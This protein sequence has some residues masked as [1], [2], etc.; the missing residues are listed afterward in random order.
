MKNMESGRL[1]EL[2]E[3]SA[4]INSTLDG[5]EIR[6]R[7]MEAAKRLVNAET[8]SLLLV[9]QETQ[10][11]FFEVA[12]GEQG[13]LLKEIRLKFGQGIAGWVALNG[14][15]LIIGDAY[16]DPRFYRNADEKSSFVTRDMICVPVRF[17][18]RILGVLE[19]INKREGRFGDDDLRLLLALSNQVAIAVENSNLYER[20]REAFFGTA[21]S[22]ADSLEKRDPYTGGHT[23]RVRHYSVAIGGLLGLDRAEMEILT[24]AAILHDIG[25]IGVRD[26]VL[27]K[28]GKLDEDEF[29][30]MVRHSRY[31][32]EILAHVKGLQ[33]VMAGVKGHH[34]KYDGSGYPDR[35]AGD[36]IPLAARIIAVADSFDAMTTDRPYSK[37]LT[38]E[39]AL[40]ELRCCSGRQ[41]DPDVVRAFIRA[42]EEGIV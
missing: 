29:D 26:N 22:L 2:M 30:S 3:L 33:P 21:L 19:V 37:A 36:E 17:R 4:L 12:L 1:Y 38:F 23:Q 13:S 11:L 31:G 10:E 14:E 7:A 6:T 32:A 34:E 40:A 5:R 16:A 18:E 41:F 28:E 27:L 15:P 42:R 20:L 9:D 35:L 24:L 39:E 8:A 25:K